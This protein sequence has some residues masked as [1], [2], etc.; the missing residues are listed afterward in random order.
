MGCKKSDFGSFL[1]LSWAA[2]N[3]TEGQMLE[4]LTTELFLM[5]LTSLF[6]VFHAP[7]LTIISLKNRIILLVLLYQ[8]TFLIIHCYLGIGILCCL[9]L[10]CKAHFFMCETLPVLFSSPY[11]WNQSDQCNHAQNNFTGKGRPR[12]KF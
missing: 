1:A 11:T 12:F 9:V 2:H 4:I 8:G 7:D 3:N 6:T 5:T 10:V